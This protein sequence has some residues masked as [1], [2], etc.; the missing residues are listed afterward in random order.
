MKYIIAN[1]KQNGDKQFITDYA[2][3]INKLLKT[4]TNLYIALPSGYLYMSNLF[5]KN[6]INIGAQNISNQPKGAFTGELGANMAGDLGA[7][8]TLIG[9][10]E[11]RNIYGETNSQIA[12]KIALAQQYGLL[13][14]LCVGETL[15]DKSK[16][17][18]VLSKQLKESLQNANLDNLIIAYEPVWAIGTGLTATTAD[19]VKVHKYI[20]EY[21][22]KNYGKNV[23]VLYGGSVN[24]SNSKDILALELVDG[25]LV[26]GA[27]LKPDQFAQ[28]YNSAK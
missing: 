16:Y 24:A 17:K 9:H 21:M 4:P 28:I 22:S 2:K 14:V 15:Q 1:F 13:V 20:K 11:R 19:I 7:N 12:Q 23:A 8:F 26:G 27:S 10:S 25:V 18:S 3:Q 6:K 5:S